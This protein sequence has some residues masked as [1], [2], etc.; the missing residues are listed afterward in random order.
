[1]S[2]DAFEYTPALRPPPVPAHSSVSSSLRPIAS[3]SLGSQQQQQQPQTLPGSSTS[4]QP[5]SHHQQAST[6]GKDRPEAFSVF[7][8]RDPRAVGPVDGLA[9]GNGLLASSSDNSVLIWGLQEWRITRALSGRRGARYDT[10]CWD[11]RNLSTRLVSVS[12]LDRSLK[13]WDLRAKSD[14]LPEVQL[15][16]GDDRSALRSA[17]W[18]PDGNTIVL[19]SS[20]SLSVFDIRQGRVI[21]TKKFDVGLNHVSFQATTA[22][23]LVGTERGTVEILDPATLV[24]KRSIWAHPA[25]VTVLATSPKNPNKFATGGSDALVELWSLNQSPFGTVDYVCKATVDRHISRIESLSF[26]GNGKW[27]AS[28]SYREKTID[29]SSAETG[30]L[31]TSIVFDQNIRT[32]CFD[33]GDS[34]EVAN[35]A[36]STETSRDVFVQPITGLEGGQEQRPTARSA[37]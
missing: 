32:V 5:T 15:R 14:T 36:F 25:Q 28:S 35:L 24:S 1:M 23:L 18:N 37:Y 27:V 13:M 11:P 34:S 8:L 3:L 20:S 12:S 17:A 7:A 10:L 30:D 19:G 31:I 33:L 22:N 6:A 2:L 4:P 26:S 29:V 21:F 16:E 9:F